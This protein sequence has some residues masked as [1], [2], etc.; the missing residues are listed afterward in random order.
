[1]QVLQG[2]QARVK[3]AHQQHCREACVTHES[4]TRACLQTSAWVLATGWCAVGTATVRL[5]GALAGLAGWAAAVK[6]TCV[7]APATGMARAQQVGALALARVRDPV[8]DMTYDSPDATLYCQS[9]MCIGT[10]GP[11]SLG[12]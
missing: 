1:M 9:A 5:A 4:H 8:R 6:L 7:L 10:W 3:E 11:S 12:M 2:Y